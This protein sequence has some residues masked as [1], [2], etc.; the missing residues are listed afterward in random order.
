MKWVRKNIE[1]ENIPAIVEQGMVMAK[2]GNPLAEQ[3]RCVFTL[4]DEKIIYMI[5]L[6]DFIDSPPEKISKFY[7]CQMAS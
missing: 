6:L 3:L 5:P 1:V 7:L 4:E 2:A